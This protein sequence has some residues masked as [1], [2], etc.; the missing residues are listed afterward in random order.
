MTLDSKETRSTD[1]SPLQAP[2]AASLVEVTTIWYTLDAESPLQPAVRH[3]D[4]VMCELSA[5]YQFAQKASRT[6]NGGWTIIVISGVEFAAFR[7]GAV[8]HLMT[9]QRL[10]L[11]LRGRTELSSPA[12]LANSSE[13]EL[14]GPAS[15]A[16][17]FPSHTAS[18]KR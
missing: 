4:T 1:A 3:S 10:L 14:W 7:N 6:Q 18:V 11:T 12:S 9:V 5:A 16:L 15:P 17:S 13:M 2:L 8:S